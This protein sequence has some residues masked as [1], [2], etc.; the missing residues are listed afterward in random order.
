MRKIK[1]V[2]A[3]LLVVTAL[4]A[5]DNQPAPSAQPASLPP[6]TDATTQN[7][8]G[9]SQWRD[10]SVSI[11]APGPTGHVQRVPI[12][13]IGGTYHVPVAIDNVCCLPAVLDTGASDVM[14]PIEIWHAMMR[15]G[16]INKQSHIGV[17]TYNTASGQVQGLRFILPPIAVGDSSSRVTARNVVGVVTKSPGQSMLLGQSF[18]RKFKSWSIDNSTNQ[19]L[20]SY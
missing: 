15:G 9:R 6:C 12:K 5:C 13:L 17:E 4:V 19:L 10:T 11:A 16:R 18:L 1:R 20:L 2:A 7:C 14:V 3:A 8:W